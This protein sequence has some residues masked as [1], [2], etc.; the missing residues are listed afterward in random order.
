MH[1][2][3]DLAPAAPELLRLLRVKR[4]LDAVLGT[5]P[6]DDTQRPC[7]APCVARRQSRYGLTVF[8]KMP[9]LGCITHSLLRSQAED[10][11]QQDCTRIFLNHDLQLCPKASLVLASLPFA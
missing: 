6:T 5:N 11:D 2:V 9:A 8:S 4:T 7:P 3:P 10:G 1:P